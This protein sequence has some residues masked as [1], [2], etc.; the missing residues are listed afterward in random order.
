MVIILAPPHP[1]LNLNLNLNILLTIRTINIRT[2]NQ[3]IILRSH[4]P[5][6]PLNPNLNLNLN[7]RRVTLG[8]TRAMRVTTRALTMIKE[9]MWWKRR[10]PRKRRARQHLSLLLKTRLVE[11][12][13]GN[14]LKITRRMRNKRKG[15][16]KRSEL[17]FLQR[18]STNP[19]LAFFQIIVLL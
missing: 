19:R 2:T 16:S 12:T 4:S 5:H 9:R 13:K 14:I 3:V 10:A 17:Y 8:T 6:L 15:T 18:F 1:N 7:L 11:K